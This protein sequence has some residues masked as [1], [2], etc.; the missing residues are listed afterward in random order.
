[1]VII[2]LFDRINYLTPVVVGNLNT[3][4]EEQLALDSN[5]GL[6]IVHELPIPFVLKYL[7]K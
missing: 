5:K 6:S 3:L 2:N 1:M 7:E 4:S